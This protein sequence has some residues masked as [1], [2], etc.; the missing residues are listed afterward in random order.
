MGSGQLLHAASSRWGAPSK[1]DIL[2][3]ATLVQRL[4]SPVRL[5]LNNWSNAQLCERLAGYEGRGR[6]GALFEKCL[7]S[8]KHHGNLDMLGACGLCSGHVH[9]M[10]HVGISWKP[11]TPSHMQSPDLVICQNRH[12]APWQPLLLVFVVAAPG[13]VVLHSQIGVVMPAAPNAAPAS[14]G[15]PQPVGRVQL[16]FGGSALHSC[17]NKSASNCVLGV[18]KFGNVCGI[19]IVQLLHLLQKALLPKLGVLV[20]TGTVNVARLAQRGRGVVGNKGT[21]KPWNMTKKGVLHQKYKELGKNIKK[22]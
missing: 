2:S 11:L 18:A 5:L 8:L 4:C 20:E 21:I 19:Q 14:S 13:R 3:A 12:A 22:N 9:G 16:A 10:S 15:R 6:S 7:E 17:V 1:P